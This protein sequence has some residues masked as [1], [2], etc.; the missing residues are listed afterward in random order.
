[1]LQG[2]ALLAV[3][4]QYLRARWYHPGTGR[5]TQS[6]AIMNTPTYQYASAN[7]INRI[8]PSGYIDW[9]ACVITGAYG[10]CVIEQGDTLYKIARELQGAGIQSQVGLSQVVRDIIGYNPA[11]Q[12]NPNYI[13]IGEPLT[14]PTD[15]I[16]A[17]QAPLSAS[18][19]DALVIVITPR[20]PY[21]PPGLLQT[22]C[23]AGCSQDSLGT[24]LPRWR[25]DTSNYAEFCGSPPLDYLDAVLKSFQHGIS[26]W[27]TGLPYGN[28]YNF[29]IQIMKDADT[30]TCALNRGA[31]GVTIVIEQMGVGA[32]SVYVA[33]HCGMGLG[34]AAGG[35]SGGNL[36]VF[37][38]GY[39]VGWGACYLGS[40]HVM[41]MGVDYANE[42]V[43]F[44]WL[45]NTFCKSQ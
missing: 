3:G 4:L 44:P 39:I 19:V 10:T 8:D 15:W 13:K 14:L 11:L 20:K 22:T 2:V 25:E 32:L 29:V 16:S 7:P 6:D 27:E 26:G 12:A 41:M 37:G 30:D 17:L 23:F 24:P 33:G 1:M 38:A 45:E 21:L 18:T 43:F 5:F 42:E 35:L 9:S 28:F 40:Y 34:T 36:G 31:R